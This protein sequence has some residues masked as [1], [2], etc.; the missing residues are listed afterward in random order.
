MWSLMRARHSSGSIASKL[1]GRVHPRAVEHRL[2]AVEV[3]EFLEREG[4]SDEVGGGVLQALLV[5]GRDRLTHVGGEAG[6]SPGEQLL[7]QLPGDRPLVEQAA[8][9]ALAEQPHQPL[10]VPLR[11]RVPRAVGA[12]AAVSGDEVQVRSGRDEALGVLE[13]YRGALGVSPDGQTVLYSSL[14][15]AGADL[16]LLEGFR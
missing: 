6:M 10:G 11:Q 12:S 16:V 14:T 15:W 5:F 8:E 13:Q 7:D 9:Q 2:L 4:I 3:D 1:R